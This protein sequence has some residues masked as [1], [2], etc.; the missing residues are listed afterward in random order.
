MSSYYEVVSFSVYKKTQILCG[1]L[2]LGVQ[3]FGALTRCACFIARVYNKEGR[4]VYI[5]IISYS[6][7]V[8]CNSC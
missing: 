2:L 6:T 7:I 8:L 3:L 1:L 4:R 5:Y